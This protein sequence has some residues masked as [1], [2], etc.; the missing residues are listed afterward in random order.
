ML[1]SFAGE[2]G[3]D[4]I[5]PELKTHATNDRIRG[6]IG[7]AGQFNVESA[8]SNVGCS[9]GRWDEGLEGIGRGIIFPKS[10]CGLGQSVFRRRSRSICEAR[11]FTRRDLNSMFWLLATRTLKCFYQLGQRRR[12]T[13][14]TCGR[15]NEDDKAV[16]A[17][18]ADIN[19][20]N[21]SD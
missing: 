14:R 20:S 8:D 13:M 12:R 16:G 2:G 7:D 18:L 17:A 9:G 11:E 4:A 10:R 1:R 15:T 6:G 19:A 5:A 3:V 21:T